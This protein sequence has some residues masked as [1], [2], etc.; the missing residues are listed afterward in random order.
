MRRASVF[1][2]LVNFRLYPLVLRFSSVSITPP[3]A[4]YPPSS[5]CCSY[6][7]DERAKPGNLPKI[8]VLSE[9]IWFRKYLVEK[10]FTPSIFFWVVHLLPIRCWVFCLFTHMDTYTL[11][12]TFRDEGS[13]R[14]R[15]LYLTKHNIYKTQ[16][17]I[18][19][20]G[21]EPAI[22]ATER[23]QNY[24]VDCTAIGIFFPCWKQLIY[25]ELFSTHELGPFYNTWVL[26]SVSLLTL[27]YFQSCT[28]KESQVQSV[29]MF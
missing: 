15:K 4:P 19:L 12:R 2:S 8:N 27:T 17:S 6:Q 5:M 16:T 11:G 10:Y 1:I 24:A 28:M 7:K 3:H 20:A 22:S 25:C 13:A 23:P 18:S 29:G 9:V 21:F 14:P 26:L